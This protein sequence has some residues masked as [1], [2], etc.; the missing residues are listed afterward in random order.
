[1]SE[2]TIEREDGGPDEYIC[3]DCST[4]YPFASLNPMQSFA[5]RVSAG[6]VVPAGECPD[7]D[8][9]ALCY[10]VKIEPEVA[11]AAT[12]DE[13]LELLRQVAEDARDLISCNCSYDRNTP[14]EQRCDGTCTHSMAVRALQQLQAK[15]GL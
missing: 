5:E 11:P 8:C 12:A 3:D 1:M 2:P 9:G 14:P 13:T 4:I 7:E 10:P 6:G 15:G